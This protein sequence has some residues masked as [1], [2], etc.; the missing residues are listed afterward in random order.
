[1]TKIIL[2]V[3]LFGCVPNISSVP[4][5]PVFGYISK[6]GI[7]AAKRVKIVEDKNKMDARIV[8]GRPS[9]LGQQPYQAGLIASIMGTSDK[10]LCGGSLI[11]ADRILTA[12]HCWYDGMTQAWKFE[13]VL[14]SVRLFSGGT[15]VNTSAVSAHPDWDP[16]LVRND[17]AVVYLPNQVTSPGLVVTI[18]PIALPTTTELKQDFV[19]T[20]AVASGFGLTEEDAQITSDQQLNYAKLKIIPNSVCSLSYPYFIHASNI[21]T[22]SEQ[23]ST[24]CRGD[25]GGPLVV[26]VDG[27]KILIGVTSFGSMFGCESNS[28]AVYTRV[29]SYLSFIYQ[30]VS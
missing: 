3:F 2:I 19:G 10:S 12:A 28:P 7:P 4:D 13:V 21:C 30:H 26:K 17:I 1:M 27:R 29:T 22:S 5:N 16:S 8:G 25:S 18:S 11:T 23:G 15:R 6:Y 14:G 20:K 9:S 24:P